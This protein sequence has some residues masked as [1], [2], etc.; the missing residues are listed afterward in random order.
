MEL[1]NKATLTMLVDRILAAKLAGEDAEVQ[2][3]ERQIDRHVFNLYGLTTEE[4]A[5]IQTS[6]NS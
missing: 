3:I 5:L 4:V 6:L 1:G 2:E